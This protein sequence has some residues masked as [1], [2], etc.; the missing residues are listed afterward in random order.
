MLRLDLGLGC[1][2][3]GKRYRGLE[4]RVQSQTSEV[5]DTSDVLSEYIS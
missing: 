4:L 1:Q 3:I 2:D 5:Y